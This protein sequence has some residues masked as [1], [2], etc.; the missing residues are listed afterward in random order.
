MPWGIRHNKISIGQG[1]LIDYP[2]LESPQVYKGLAQVRRHFS[3]GGIVGHIDVD[4]NHARVIGLLGQGPIELTAKPEPVSCS[5]L[6]FNGETLTCP[7]ECRGKFAVRPTV[8]I[9]ILKFD[10]EPSPDERRSN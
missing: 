4:E 2:S 1:L 8:V 3:V 9:L 7:C 6:G 10:L 5:M